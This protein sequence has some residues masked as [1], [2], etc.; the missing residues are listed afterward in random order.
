MLF[1]DVVFEGLPPELRAH[2][3]RLGRFVVK[4]KADAV[5]LYECYASDAVDLK[6]AKESS[7]GRFAEMVALYSDNDLD[8]ALPI[9]SGLRDACPEDGPASWWHMRLL[10]ECADDAIPSSNGLVVLDAK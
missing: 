10:K 6:T 2:T 8:G 7:R 3:R 9:A 5:E 4:G 1:S